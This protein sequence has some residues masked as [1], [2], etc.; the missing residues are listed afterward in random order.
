MKRRQ[1]GY[2]LVEVLVA[3]SII[4]AVGSISYAVVQ[5]ALQRAY[6]MHC[7]GNLRELGSALQLYIADHQGNFPT[8]VSA[9]RDRDSEEPA[10]DNTLDEYATDPEVFHCR[11]DHGQFFEKTGCSYFWNTV[12]NDQNAASLSFLTTRDA[13]R[14]PVISDKEN[15]HRYQGIEVNILFADGAVKK[16]VMF[17]VNK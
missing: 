9:R 15:F 13:T 4:V 8:L 5:K 6:A 16:D 10:L 17:S 3:I 11:A 2:T 12:L 7:T 1:T 14:I